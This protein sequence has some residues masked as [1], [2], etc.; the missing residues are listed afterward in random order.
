MAE[1][2]GEQLIHEMDSFLSETAPAE[3]EADAALP[4]ETIDDYFNDPTGFG[5]MAEKLLKKVTAV[6]DLAVKYNRHS[7]DYLKCCARLERGIKYLG[8]S[9]LQKYAL[10]QH[11]HA[12][13]N[14]GQLNTT[15]LYT[16]AAVHFN[17]IDRALSEFME[18]KQTVDDALLDMEYRYYHLM[19]RIRATE[20]K[21]NTFKNKL[22][23]GEP[24]YNPVLHGLA[25]SEKSWAKS[26]H[27][28]DEPLPFQR[29]RAFS[30][31][32]SGNKAQMS[33]AASGNEAISNQIEETG[34]QAV[35]DV[36]LGKNS[37]TEH[38]DGSEHQ[39]TSIP[40]RTTEFEGMQR[41]QFSKK[42]SA[43]SLHH[44]V[45]KEE[46]LQKKDPA[47]EGS[48]SGSPSAAVSGKRSLRTPKATSQ[49]EKEIP[50]FIRILERAT[51]RSRQHNLDH[52]RFTEQEIRF[53]AADPGFAKF[54]P[55]MAAEMRRVL[56][57]QDGG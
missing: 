42:G 17:K 37:D 35:A 14:L 8:S 12:F 13:P 57:L 41:E 11:Q 21:L 43:G 49:T 26:I 5:D 24:D 31:Q 23:A 4:F 29:A 33:S 28:N 38:K 52:I 44:S 46:R 18:Q 45:K 51:S 48:A 39:H 30:L 40:G 50:E 47:C 9:C 36:Q 25:F 27:E 7:Q 54:R 1:N 19:E 10:E 32:L 53:L 20:V 15:N 2:S 22:I 16:M 3:A 56:E 6:F 55:E 34:P